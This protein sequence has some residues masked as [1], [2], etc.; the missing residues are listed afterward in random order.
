MI[1]LGPFERNDELPVSGIRTKVVKALP[2][3][4]I[5]VL[6][7]TLCELYAFSVH[8]TAQDDYDRSSRV[9]YT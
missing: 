8:K 4:L 2:Q 1:H 9:S 5:T 7:I 6:C 3:G